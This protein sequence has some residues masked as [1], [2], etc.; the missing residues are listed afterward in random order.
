MMKPFFSTLTGRI[1]VVALLLFVVLAPLLF[2]GVLY[3]VQKN[4]ENQFVDSVRND[5]YQMASMSQADTG[6]VHLEAELEEAMIGGRLK[7]S[8]I[9]DADGYRVVAGKPLRP[10]TQIE[11]DF[12]FGQ[13][14]DSM[15][16]ITVP[17][18]DAAREHVGELQ[19]GYDEIP[20]QE[21]TAQAYRSGLYLM[22]GF[23]VV[24]FSTTI[25]L[26]RQFSYPIQQ[27]GEASK[28]IAEGDYNVG[29][30]VK[31]GIS[32]FSDLAI[33]LD[34]MRHELVQKNS[35]MQHQAQ[36]DSLTGLPNRSLLQERVEAALKGARDEDDSL[37]FL[38]IDL[39]KF[40]AVND[41]LGHLTG[42]AVLRL[43][44]ERMHHCVR[45]TDTAA[46]LGGDEFALLLP[47]TGGGSAE[48]IA[49]LVSE[50][51][52]EDFEVGD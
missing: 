14:G 22:L 4:Y 46:R 36:H 44:A 21:L 23:I 15:Y 47:A 50:R 20:T 13:A 35:E 3:L 17:L 38:L 28:K 16:Y 5:A 11:E 40:K 31:S 43:A 42:D 49:R 33:S 25:L 30:Q 18:F 27:L 8:R 9:V 19:L 48:A 2:G 45:E 1:V 7:F 52:Q 51:L 37:A 24:I 41:T 39:D 6:L 26:A 10:A 34:H 12:Y 32:E 29:L